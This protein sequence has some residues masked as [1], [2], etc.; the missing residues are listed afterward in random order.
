MALN[1]LSPATLTHPEHGS[2]QWTKVSPL[3]CAGLKGK[4]KEMPWCSI[5]TIIN[6]NIH[7]KVHGISLH[8]VDDETLVDDGINPIGNLGPKEPKGV[9]RMSLDQY[10]NIDGYRCLDKDFGILLSNV[11]HEDTKH[12]FVKHPIILVKDKD[13]KNQRQKDKLATRRVPYFRFVLKKHLNLSEYGAAIVYDNCTPNHFSLVRVREGSN[14]QDV[15]RWLAFPSQGIYLPYDTSAILEHHINLNLL[16]QVDTFKLLGKNNEPENCPDVSN[17]FLYLRKVASLFK[18]HDMKLEASIE[19]M[20]PR[21]NSDNDNKRQLMYKGAVVLY[22]LDL[23]WH[24]VSCLEELEKVNYELEDLDQS[25][26]EMPLIS[27]EESQESH[28]THEAILSMNY[29]NSTDYNSIEYKDLAEA[30]EALYAMWETLY[31]SLNEEATAST[32]GRGMSKMQDN[33][34]E[35]NVLDE[36]YVENDE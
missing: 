15:R 11:S 26:Q 8:R 33:L 31:D 14:L 18:I 10:K 7:F 6:N 30:D 2:S 17:E 3:Y 34:K 5:K 1:Q 16:E 19:P 24:V 21:G 23:G 13:E 36:A 12:R 20:P 4:E 28:D 9:T 27:L 29:F 25:L 32:I 22:H 35:I